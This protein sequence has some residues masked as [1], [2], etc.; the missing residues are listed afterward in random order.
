MFGPTFD[1]PNRWF[2]IEYFVSKDV[3]GFSYAFILFSLFNGK[4]TFGWERAIVTRISLLFDLEPW[5][6]HNICDAVDDPFILFFKLI[7]LRVGH[8]VGIVVEGVGVG[9]SL[10]F[11]GWF[12]VFEI[13]V[14]PGFV[15]EV[16]ELLCFFDV[17][18]IIL[19]SL[20]FVK[21]TDFIDWLII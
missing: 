17:H 3:I 4:M 7:P 18:L 13:R 10:G 11:D 15:L 20:I 16:E 12:Y 2:G 19:C 21:Q 5:S 8:S 14:V 1:S 9:V 6:S